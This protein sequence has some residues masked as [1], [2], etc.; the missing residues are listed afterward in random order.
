MG[1]PLTG[2]VRQQGSRWWAS[3]PAAK[4]VD[5]RKEHSFQSQADAEAWLAQAVIAVRVGKPV[6]E[7]DSFRTPAPTPRPKPFAKPVVPVIRPDVASVA[8]A[9]MTAAYDDLRRGG[10]E[11]ADRVRRIVEAYLVP[12]FAPRTTSIADVTYPMA[13]EWLLRLVGRDRPGGTG[14]VPKWPSSVRSNDREAALTLTEVAEAAGVSL[15]TA[16]RRW[17]AGQ[18]PGAYL[19]PTGR[20]CV[21]AAAVAAITTRSKAPVGLSQGYVSDALWVLRRILA[22]ARANGLFPPG[23]DPTEGLDAP[24]ADKAVSRKASQGGQVRPLT[25]GECARLASHLHAVHQI[26]LWTQRIM[27]LRISE[28]FGVTVGD[29]FDLGDTGLLAVQSQGGRSFTVRDDHGQVVAVPNKR[30]LKTA[31]GSR[32]LVVPPKLMELIRVAIDPF[33]TDPDTGEVDSSGRLIPGL[34]S[35]NSSGQAAYRHAFDEAAITEEISSEHLGFS[36]STHL[37]RKSCATDLAWTVGIEDAVRRRFMGHRAGDDVFGRIYTLDHPDVAPLAKVAEILDHNIATSIGGLM[38]PTIRRVHWGTTNPT[39]SRADYIDATLSAAGWLVEPG[40]ADDPLCDA[41]RVAA[42][43][44]IYPTTARRWMIDGTIPTVAVPDQVGV[45]RRHSRLSDIWQLRDR[46]AGQILLPDLAY[47]L[48]LPYHE[49]YNM[50]QRLGLEVEQRPGHNE[51]LLTEEVAEALG[52][53]HRRIQALRLRSM[54]L[55]GAARALKVALSTAALMSRTGQLDVDPESDSSGARFVVR[56]SVQRCWLERPSHNRSKRGLEPG[57]PIAE[58]VRYTGETLQ[59]IRDLVA[60][61]VLDTVC[62]QRAVEVTT[63][64]LRAWMATGNLA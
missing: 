61:G 16:R 3:V 24:I 44:N 6:P 26:A 39:L 49:A 8:Q 51:Y 19:D 21:P 59:A 2:S 18:L 35:P 30:T 15:P 25:L 14:K 36:V 53:E 55:T 1:R 62:G 22:F 33:H 10:P 11:R 32:V 54:K 31:A 13:H 12:W 5:R 64:S 58:V 7:P 52:I 48:G 40:D 27:G 50:L 23:F 38:T 42:E 41:K 47:D 57:V 4:G 60:G 28:A 37:L 46:L 34:Q 17:R 9:W 29:V 56:T 20:I 45:E 43:L 63:A